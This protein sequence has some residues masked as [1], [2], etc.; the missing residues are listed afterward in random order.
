M[1]AAPP[2]P[3]GGA[4]WGASVL[5]GLGVSGS[6]RR[7]PREREMEPA[8]A[9]GREEGPLGQRGGPG[10]AGAGAGAG[11]SPSAAGPVV[12]AGG[13]SGSPEPGPRVLSA[14]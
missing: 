10:A 4:G 14:A 6:G 13:E 2:P 7:P 9:A 12:A 1:A 5:R 3:A 8:A 11:R